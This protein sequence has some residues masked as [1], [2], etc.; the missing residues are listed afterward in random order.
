M[1]RRRRLDLAS[2]TLVAA[3]YAALGWWSFSI[4]EAFAGWVFALL[5]L[6]YVGLCLYRRW[7]H[8]SRRR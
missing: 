7:L 8:R 2:E 1:S 6:F 5:S 4:G 3:I